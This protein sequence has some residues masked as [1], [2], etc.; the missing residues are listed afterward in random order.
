M[1][2]TFFRGKLILLAVAFWL[3]IMEFFRLIFLYIYAAD[4]AKA[5]LAHTLYSLVMA[6]HIDVST[7]GYFCLPLCIMLLV[8]LFLSSKTTLL[9]VK[10][11]VGIITAIYSFVCIAET[12][13]YADWGTK[14]N[15]K[16]A[17]YILQPQEVL[18]TAG[19]INVTLG[20]L[21]VIG[22]VTL[23]MYV[24]NILV[25]K[26]VLPPASIK[27]TTKYKITSSTM[28]IL[29][30]GISIVA[31]RGGVQE[32]PI[33]SGIS[34]YSSYNTLNNAAVNPLWNVVHS[35]I[36]NH[37]YLNTNPYEVMPNA[38][39]ERL[40]TQLYT[41]HTDS[42]LQVLTTTRPNIVLFLLE[43][44]SADVV[45]ACGGDSGYTPNLQRL[46]QQGITFNNIYATGARSDEGI[47]GA[48]GGFPD[49]P[50]TS[51]ITQP[52]K[53]PHVPCIAKD[54]K[55]QGY[56]TAFYFGGQLEY[57]NIKS[58]LVYNGFDKLVEV[59]DF[60][61]V[62]QGKLGAHDEY[63]TARMLTD[64]N[65]MKQPFLS[66]LFTTST[67]PPYD[68]PPFHTI[69]YGTDYDEYLNAVRYSDSCIGNFITQAQ[70]QAWYAN[71]LFIIVA[72]HSKRTHK[73][74]PWE[75]PADKHIPL[76]MFGNVI[77]KK[78][79]GT[80]ITQLGSQTDLSKTLLTQLNIN[81][82]HYT[83]G[84]NLLN[85]RSTNF[86][87][88]SGTSGYGWLSTK[89]TFNYN[90]STKTITT[91]KIHSTNKDSVLHTSQA[92]MQVLFKRYLEY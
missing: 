22:F 86:A 52:S 36:E 18:L 71:T 92:Y 28:L 75:S 10:W 76:A 25:T 50:E 24:F 6:V 11:Y 81:N 57:E 63:V 3:G 51:I 27:P 85:P 37:T 20:L 56:Y 31:I 82:T 77:N 39:A 43:S 9:M 84:K 54:L 8:S 73:Q 55:A 45:L 19:Y 87:F 13:L 62:P 65:S 80:V 72:D 32:I 58:Y 67:H 59:D 83:W 64:V 21:A 91:N 48:L 34:Y 2:N 29:A 49:Q 46:M 14:L 70:T 60:D 44:M 26:F 90:Y 4:F 23:T 78:Y 66:C 61:N 42:G 74:H 7:L 53:Y 16:A 41:T 89:D 12:Q 68:I 35:I 47:A 88:Y 69:K 30:T 33:Q 17:M 1:Y 79:R 38:E 5:S 40:V 15:Y